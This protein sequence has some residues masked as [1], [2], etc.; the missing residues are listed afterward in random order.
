[1]TGRQPAFFVRSVGDRLRLVASDHLEVDAWLVQRRL[2]EA[3]AAESPGAALDAYMAALPLWRGR[4]LGDL[5][6]A[7]WLDVPRDRLEERRVAAAVR[8]G[9]LFLAR[10]RGAGALELASRALEVHPYCEP[11]YRLQAAAHLALGDRAA[12]RRSLQRCREA[13]GD[14]GVALQPET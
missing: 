6:P 7:D 2:D 13:L 14:L 11:A 5:G 10:D 8:A 4:Y 3:E 9:E 1:R 12:M